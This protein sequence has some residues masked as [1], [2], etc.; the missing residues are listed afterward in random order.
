M[1]RDYLIPLVLEWS[2]QAGGKSWVAWKKSDGRPTEANIGRYVE[3]YIQSQYRGGA[4]NHLA[5]DKGFILVPNSA[6]IVRQ[7][8]REVVATWRAPAFMVMP[9]VPKFNKDGGIVREKP[10]RAGHRARLS[11]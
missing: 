6:Q 7:P 4:N 2:D 3:A 11:R 1:G 5:R 10:P 9:P 8:G